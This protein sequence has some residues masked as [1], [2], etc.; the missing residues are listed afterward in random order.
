MEQFPTGSIY[1]RKSSCKESSL[2]RETKLCSCYYSHLKPLYGHIEHLEID[3]VPRCDDGS[4]PPNCDL[5]QWSNYILGATKDAGRP[6]AYNTETGAHLHA[7][8]F[9]DIKHQIIRLPINPWPQ[10]RHENEVGRWYNLGLT[11]GLEALTLA[12]L[13]RVYGWKREDVDRLVANTKRDICSRQYHAYNN[14]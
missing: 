9:V 2:L 11:Q 1:I 14:L 13:T 10:D 3:L 7:A 6:L 12:P 5:V 4:L 8:G